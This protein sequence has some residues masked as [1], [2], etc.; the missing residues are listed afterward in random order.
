MDKPTI[1]IKFN[2][3]DPLT[4]NQLTTLLFV[5]WLSTKD[6]VRTEPALGRG[7]PWREYSF[8]ESISKGPSTASFAD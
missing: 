4:M 1:L 5:F 8:G 2:R 7:C 6:T 3:Y